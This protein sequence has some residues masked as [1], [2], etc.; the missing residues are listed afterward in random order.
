[1]GRLS[2]KSAGRGL[3]GSSSGFPSSSLLLF[4]FTRPG[5]G[6]TINNF[7]RNVL[8]QKGRGNGGAISV[9]STPKTWCNL[10]VIHTKVVRSPCY[11]HQN[12]VLIKPTNNLGKTFDL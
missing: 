1:M 8:R 2:S 10:R 11:P 4:S 3:G 6:A 7:S 12:V 9:L 5:L